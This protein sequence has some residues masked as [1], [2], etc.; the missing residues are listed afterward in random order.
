[1]DLIGF[2]VS[3]SRRVWIEA[4][5]IQHFFKM[6]LSGCTVGGYTDI[7]YF[8]LAAPDNKLAMS[9]Y[10]FSDISTWPW[11]SYLPKSCPSCGC[12]EP[13]SLRNLE[14][15]GTIKTRCL[16]PTCNQGLE[17]AKPEGADVYTKD[18]GS[19]KWYVI[20]KIL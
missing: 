15:G 5:T 4:D 3:Y 2:L 12:I 14:K 10:F 19:G 16:Y 9:R 13:W 7:T 17:W 20:E 8:Q 18:V 11:G 6:E 1:M